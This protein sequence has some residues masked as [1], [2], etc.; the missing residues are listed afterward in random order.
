VIFSTDER[1][2]EDDQQMPLTDLISR[3]T[4]N[5]TAS[6]IP[7]LEERLA[8][9]EADLQTKRASLNALLVDGD[10]D[11]PAAIKA[12]DAFAAAERR[13]R[14]LQGA[15]AA[16]QERQRTSE[17]ENERE[18]KRAAWQA[19]VNA[20]EDR[21]T[22]VEKLA[23]SMSQF[24]ADYQAALQANAD[25]VAALPANPDNVANL[26][27][28]FALETCL[29]KELVRLGIHFAFV[30]P[31]GAATLPPLLPQFEGALEVVR[32]ASVPKDLR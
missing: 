28:R 30:W 19:A 22:A 26:T 6:N 24:A 29:R 1:K 17:V 3:I 20:A 13:V 12:E 14:N 7:K 11:S 10:T 27:D 15:L 18:A 25:L 16:A 32:R 2:P 23:A 5:V 9:A 21:H 8:G 4:A 31:Y